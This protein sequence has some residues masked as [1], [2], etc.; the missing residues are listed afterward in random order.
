MAVAL[1]IG[2]LILMW[3]CAG[4]WPHALSGTLYVQQA[5]LRV[6]GTMAYCRGGWLLFCATLSAA[7]VCVSLYAAY[8]QYCMGV[9]VHARRMA[10]L[11]LYK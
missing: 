1:P 6:V 11:E 3:P 8:L 4:A 2:N 10:S 5:L 7:G 9:D